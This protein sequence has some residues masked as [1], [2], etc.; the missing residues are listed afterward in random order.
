MRQRIFLIPQPQAINY[1]LHHIII[2]LSNILVAILL[3]IEWSK[4]IASNVLMVFRSY[5][6]VHVIKALSS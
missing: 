3:F 4:S 1:I 6:K 2:K 5:Y